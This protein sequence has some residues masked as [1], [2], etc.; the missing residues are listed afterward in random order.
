MKYLNFKKL[1]IQLLFLT[2]LFLTNCQITPSIELKQLEGYWMIEY[3]EQENEIF[4]S[5]QSNPLYDY[6]SLKKNKGQY[7]KITPQLDGALHTSQSSVAFEVLKEN[8]T[9][10]IHYS[11]PWSVWY[12]TI[13]HLDSEKLVLFHEERNFHYKRPPI[14][15]LVKTNEESER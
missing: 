7:K 9:F 8:G 15:D 6:Y 1:R 10:I 5:K 4:K 14:D 12:K 11:T 2:F 13:K 3:V